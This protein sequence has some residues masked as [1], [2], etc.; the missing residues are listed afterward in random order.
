LVVGSSADEAIIVPLLMSEFASPP[1]RPLGDPPVLAQRRGRDL[2]LGIGLTPER[3][4]QA[5]PPEDL[6]VVL[7]HWM[8]HALRGRYANVGEFAGTGDLGRDRAGYEGPLGSDPWD[9]YQCKQ[10]NRKLGPAD[11]YAEIGKLVYYATRGA[12]TVPRRYV[13]VSAKGLSPKA[14]DLLADSE[15][16]RAGLK[17]AWRTSCA[18]LCE[19]SEIADALDDFPFP[20]FQAI[21]AGQIV[22]DLKD[23]SVYPYFFGGGLTIPRPPDQIPPDE[24]ADYELPYVEKLLAAYDD[25][26]SSVISSVAGALGLEPYGPHLRDSRKDFYCAESLREFSKDAFP[27][28]KT[29]EELQQLVNDGIR[30][31][32]ARAHSSGYDR[33]LE[34]CEHATVVELGDHP[35]AGEVNPADRS[36]ICHQLAN[37]DRVTWVR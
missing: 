25:H 22:E 3:R 26:C 27:N 20:E 4:L 36:G 29:F 11:V 28:P 7:E 17:R 24:I 1:P 14:L 31:T 9:N 21:T 5:L 19:P 16:L 32:L 13:F 33:V 37:D 8:H 35:L 15:K 23:A 18:S 6:E 10:Y 30:H 12:Y 2:L 34:V